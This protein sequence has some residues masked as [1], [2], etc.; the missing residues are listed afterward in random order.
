[1]EI[2]PESG[3]QA[4]RATGITCWRAG[5]VGRKGADLSDH[6]ATDPPFGQL[7]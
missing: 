2:S 5:F 4:W 7:K 1:V 6:K 3:T